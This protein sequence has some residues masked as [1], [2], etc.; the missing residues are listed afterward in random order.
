MVG[1]EIHLATVS[2][3]VSSS[4]YFYTWIDYWN[5]YSCTLYLNNTRN[6]ATYHREFSCDFKF[7]PAT[8]FHGICGVGI[9]V[10]CAYYFRLPEL[11]L[12]RFRLKLSILDENLDDM[13]DIDDEGFSILQK[14]VLEPVENE[15]MQLYEGL[16]LTLDRIDDD[17]KVVF[18]DIDAEDGIQFGITTPKDKGLPESVGLL[19]YNVDYGYIVDVGCAS[20]PFMED[21]NYYHVTLKKRN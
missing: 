3:N 11:K 7:K 13:F 15:D 19:F 8:N 17:F 16:N 21:K 10:C 12:L 1:F 4:Q 2:K 5:G 6:S 9:G 20:R 18:A 14:D